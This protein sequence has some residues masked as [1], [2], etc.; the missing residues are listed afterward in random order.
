MLKKSL[1]SAALVALSS[2]SAFA[3]T[4]SF[5]LGAQGL[6]FMPSGDAKS[7]GAKITTKLFDPKE[8]VVTVGDSVMFPGLQIGYHVSDSLRVG[9]AG[10]LGFGDFVSTFKAKS[11]YEDRLAALADEKKQLTKDKN[12]GANLD[13]ET[14]QAS[15]DAFKDAKKNKSAAS[16]RIGGTNAPEYFI[17]VDGSVRLAS[18]TTLG[19]PITRTASSFEEACRAV[20]KAI[21]I[22]KKAEQ[23]AKRLDQLD[24]IG[25][26]KKGEIETLDEERTKFEKDKTGDALQQDGTWVETLSPKG[27]V[28]ATVDMK[29]YESDSFSLSAGLRLGTTCWKHAYELR[30][31]ISASSADDTLP[32]KTSINSWTLAGMALANANINLGD[33]ATLTLSAGYAHLGTPSDLEYGKLKNGNA[34]PAKFSVDE[35]KV[36]GFV[37]GVGLGK[38][39]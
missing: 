39:F 33:V 28:F 36:K 2:T 5:Y 16:V 34:G 25:D 27:I 26:G 22:A 32:E 20:N 21:A 38:D 31:H 37:F 1:I 12:N 35:S 24:G 3:D 10:Y 14:L 17:L 29:V 15:L 11:E 6:Y 23:A 8:K 7:A 18:R 19:A 13:A 30:D 4:E 9:V